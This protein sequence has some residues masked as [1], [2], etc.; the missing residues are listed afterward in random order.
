MAFWKNLLSSAIEEIEIPELQ[1]YSLSWISD[2]LV[3]T[4]YILRI[5]SWKK[6]ELYGG[7]DY[8]GLVVIAVHTW[9][10]M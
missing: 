6:T 9:P 5:S 8:I 10:E 2:K 3:A 1:S 4:F 7:M